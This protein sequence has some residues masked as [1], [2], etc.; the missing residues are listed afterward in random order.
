M[1]KA[2]PLQPELPL[3]GVVDRQPVTGDAR[4]IVL[5]DRIVPY[6][7]RRSRRRSIGL[8]VDEAGLRVGAP[9]RASLAE[10]EQI[11]VKHGRWVLGKLDQW[12]ARE[13]RPTIHVRD[14]A[15]LPLLGG[16]AG[17]RVETGANRFRWNDDGVI[18][19][20]RP[21][22]SAPELLE[23]ALRERASGHFAG[24]L[25]HFASR[26]ELPLPP[27]ALTAARSRWGSCSRKSGIRLNWRLIHA[28]PH[29]IDYVVVHELAHLRQMNHSA[30]FWR[31]VEAVIPD[32]HAARGELRRLSE[33][34][35]EFV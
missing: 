12:A 30:Q 31:E 3:W 21:D 22:R 28:P 20:L 4:R 6:A 2:Q 11:I 23:R 35:P 34:L 10:V 33:C 7:L 25:T 24:R 17:I 13:R 8:V 15:R 29:L 14:G 16:V 19:A 1:P 27:L 5:G 32:H 18:L 9:L 26:M